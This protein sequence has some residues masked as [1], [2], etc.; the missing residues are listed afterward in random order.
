MGREKGWKEIINF[1]F[2]LVPR[3][4]L[5]ISFR[6]KDKEKNIVDLV[7]VDEKEK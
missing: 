4:F 1:L 3:C 6:N 7:F 2:L 5:K